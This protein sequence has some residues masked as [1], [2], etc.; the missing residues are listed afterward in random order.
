MQNDLDQNFFLPLSAQALQQLSEL[1]NLLNNTHLSNQKVVGIAC[2][3]IWTKR[4]SLIFNNIQLS[5]HLWRIGFKEDFT[6][7]MHRVKEEDKQKYQSWI[8]S[9]F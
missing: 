8:D 3:Q 2:W 1:S 7:L 4:N 6:L 5:I 9:I